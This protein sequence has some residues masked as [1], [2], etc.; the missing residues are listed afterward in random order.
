MGALH[1]GHI[2]LVN[3]SRSRCR[4]TLVSIF[5]NPLQFGPS[6]DLARY[7]RPVDEDLALLAEAGVDAVF[8]PRADELTPVGATTFVTEEAVSQS[9]CGA[10]RPGHFRGVTTIVAKLF[11]LV[12]PDVAF[13]GQ[14]DAQQCAVIE[15]MVR[16]L[17]FPVEIVRGPTVR[18]ADGLAL[19][20]RNRYL[21]A[22][23]RELAPLIHQIFQEI[24]KAFRAGVRDARTLEQIGRSLLENS[25][26]FR[27]QYF[28]LRHP[29]SL[30]LVETIGR[31]GALI[32]VA[33]YLGSTR[34]ID[35]W[36]LR[37]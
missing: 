21:S 12:Q 9:L 3:V 13:F 11:N 33:A 25:R 6:E 23:E 37:G 32:A 22:Q 15:R 10:F 18:E 30:E 17:D 26:A 28:E 24:E 16:D 8:L 7:P 1:T 2:S 36:L 29:S 19:S 27:V 34:L 35:N 14:K 4:K 5:V 31:D 20:S